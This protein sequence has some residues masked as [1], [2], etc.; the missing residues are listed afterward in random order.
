MVDSNHTDNAERV[1]QFLEQRALGF[2]VLM[3]AES[4]IARY[5]GANLTTTTAVIDTEGRLRYYGNF[6]AADAAIQDLLAG[7]EVAIPESRCVG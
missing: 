1:N 6:G 5:F 7:R 2:T 3:D 4:E